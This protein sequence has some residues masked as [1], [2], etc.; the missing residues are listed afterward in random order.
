MKPTG[1]TTCSWTL[2]QIERDQVR[3]RMALQALAEP[4][5]VVIA[6]STRRLTGGLFN[7][8]D[9]GITALKGFAENVPARLG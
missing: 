9:L 2:P 5:A 8:R 3:A 4:G 6:S 1:C 7:Y